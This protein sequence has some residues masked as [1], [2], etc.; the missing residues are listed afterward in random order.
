VPTAGT[1]PRSSRGGGHLERG[2]RAGIDFVNLHF[3]RKLFGQIF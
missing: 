2:V 3:G 1:V